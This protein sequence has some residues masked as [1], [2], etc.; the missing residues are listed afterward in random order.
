MTPLLRVM[1]ARPT[2]GRH[3]R[4]LDLNWYSDAVI[5]PHPRD[6]ALFSA[7]AR[8]L[9]LSDWPWCEDAQALLLLHLIP[10]LQDL[11][12][13]GFGLLREFLGSRLT[14]QRLPSLRKFVDADLGESEAA[15]FTLLAAVM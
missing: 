15:T 1:L 3:V 12:N 6:H 13:N 7:A 9:G 14:S 10:N 8:R 4:H 5:D 11:N 2:L